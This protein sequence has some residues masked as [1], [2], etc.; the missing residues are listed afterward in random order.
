[1]SPHMTEHA[2]G[3]WQ[4]SSGRPEIH[5]YMSITNC[6]CW[7]LSREG[8]GFEEVGRGVNVIKIAFYESLEELIENEKK[9]VYIPIGIIVIFL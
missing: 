1:M 6:S 9:E 4:C 5:K 8:G 2:P 7:V 3:A